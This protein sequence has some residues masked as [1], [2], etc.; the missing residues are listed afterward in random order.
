M[1]NLSSL[2]SGLLL[3]ATE[4]VG[5]WGAKTDNAV[6]TYG[7]YNAL[8]YELRGMLRN[9]PLG[10]VNAYWDG[11]S[12]VMTMVLS[13]YMGER[14]TPAQYAGAAFITAGILLLGRGAQTL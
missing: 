3:T 6:A 4:F 7:G 14:L 8:A 1:Q 10:L 2:Q 9:K 12:N 5:D 11:L 13:Y